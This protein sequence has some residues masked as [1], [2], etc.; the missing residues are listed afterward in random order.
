MSFKIFVADD[1]INDNLDEISR[2]PS[3]LQAA[4]YEVI[5]TP[6]GGAVYDLVF[7]SK[8]D[9]VVLDIQFKNQP[10]DGFDIC[11]SIRSND[12][13]IPVVLITSY[14]TSLSDILRGF[15]I[16]ISDYIVR[17]R[18]NHEI[19]ARIRAN[20]PSEVLVIDDYLC[21]DLAG[22]QVFIKR[23][24]IWQEAHLQRLEFDLLK[25]LVMNAGLVMLISTLKGKIWEDIKS[26]DVLGVYIHRLREKIEP[27]PTHPK[28]IETIKGF[29][30]RFTGK[31]VHTSQ[32]FLE[33]TSDWKKEGRCPI[34]GSII[35]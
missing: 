30:Y 28:Y 25:V 29:G 8:P 32:R 4:G 24:G 17:P 2:L 12:P 10:L 14:A 22:L 9:V 3:M 26:D 31:P 11:E 18:D 27:D 19:I 16:G 33:K 13:D 35:T 21:V 34:C 6:D 15:E 23:N 7:E 1:N 5:A 20:L